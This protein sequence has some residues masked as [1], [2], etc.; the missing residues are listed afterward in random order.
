MRTLKIILAVTIVLILNSYSHASSESF[1]E[2]Y[3]AYEAKHYTKAFRIW[4]K[5]AKE[6]DS[7]AQ[8]NIGWLYE[9][10]LGVERN[11]QKACFWYTKAS[12]KD[13][14]AKVHLAAMI[15]KGKCKNKDHNMAIRLLAEAAYEGNKN[16]YIV[17]LL[18]WYAK[19]NYSAAQYELALL[20]KDGI[21][22]N[23]NDKLAFQWCQKAA[24]KKHAANTMLG[25]MY[26]R[27]IGVKRNTEQAE[28]ILLKSALNP[29][30]SKDKLLLAELYYDWK[31]DLIRAY[32]W[33]ELSNHIKLKEGVEGILALVLDFEEIFPIF[34]I[35]SEA[36][37]KM[38]K[39][40]QKEAEKK[41]NYWKSMYDKGLPGVKVRHLKSLKT[42]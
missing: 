41:L 39:K 15:A 18:T 38:N 8:N 32:V 19:N 2:G 23:K 1:D 22:V 24:S 13:V 20:Y 40:Q 25:E 28:A 3:K 29:E 27:G 5:L 37:E 26:L 35:V 6:G 16:P 42:K 17:D 11:D 33:G 34:L 10:G 7:A 4:I 31:K 30:T 36:K 12:N 21:I 14:L 9:N